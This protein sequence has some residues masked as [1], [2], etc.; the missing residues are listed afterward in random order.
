MPKVVGNEYKILGR[1]RRALRLT[2]AQVAERANCSA[3]YYKTVEQ[4]RA[5][6]GVDRLI[7]I[8][9]ALN[10]PYPDLWPLFRP[11]EPVPDRIEVRPRKRKGTVQR[12]QPPQMAQMAVEG[13][14]VRTFVV[15]EIRTDE[16]RPR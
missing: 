3:G 8:A 10:L 16:R 9:D 4:G 7:R 2:Q 11:G 1:R 14:V 15:Y 6:P 5:I 12:P 13:T